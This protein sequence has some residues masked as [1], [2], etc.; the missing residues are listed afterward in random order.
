MFSKK[1]IEE[2]YKSKQHYIFVKQLKFT[3]FESKQYRIYNS[4]FTFFHPIRSFEI[5]NLD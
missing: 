2:I 4:I 3:D 1:I 5:L